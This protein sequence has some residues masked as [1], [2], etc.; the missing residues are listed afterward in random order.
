MSETAIVYQI[1]MYI[2]AFL[3]IP[4]FVFL[5]KV[6]KWVFSIVACGEV[7]ILV[8]KPM[9]RYRSEIKD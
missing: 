2:T 5:K 4:Q 8:G 6:Q 7:I 1:C 3:D 9:A